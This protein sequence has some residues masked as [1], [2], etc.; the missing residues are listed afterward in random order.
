MQHPSCRLNNCGLP[1][2]A[3]QDLA[4]VLK[5]NQSLTSLELGENPLNDLGVIYLCDG[6]TNVYCKL[7]RLQ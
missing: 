3:C 2:A 4:S 7:Q 6:L 1:A 5:S